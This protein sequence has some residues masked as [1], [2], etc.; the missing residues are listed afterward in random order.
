M[1]ESDGKDFDKSERDRVLVN[2]VHALTV[3]TEDG[4]QQVLFH[5]PILH[6]IELLQKIIV[7]DLV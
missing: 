5:Q 1:K 6:P 7:R 4:K 3:K 2:I